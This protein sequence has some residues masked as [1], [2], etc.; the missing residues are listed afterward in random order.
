MQIVI[1]WLFSARALCRRLIR[2]FKAEL[3][4]GG[5]LEWIVL[6]RKGS[7]LAVKTMLDYWLKGSHF[8]RSAMCVTSEGVRVNLLE[9]GA[10]SQAIAGFQVPCF[11]C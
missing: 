3:T 7:T 9:V 8:L 5:S 11:D 1:G 2:P 6:D 4:Q 10:H